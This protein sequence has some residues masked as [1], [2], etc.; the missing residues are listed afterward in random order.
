MNETDNKYINEQENKQFIAACRAPGKEDSAQV[1]ENFL[2]KPLERLLDVP[3]LVLQQAVKKGDVKLVNELLKNGDEIAQQKMAGHLPYTVSLALHNKKFD[4]V[5]ILFLHQNDF[6]QQELPKLTVRFFEAVLK[7]GNIDL[8]KMILECGNK[9]VQEKLIEGAQSALQTVYDSKRRTLPT[10][11]L[12]DDQIKYQHKRLELMNLLLEHPHTDFQKA[13]C[14]EAYL[15]LKKAIE[16]HEF[17]VCKILLKYKHIVLKEQKQRT[18]LIKTF[19]LAVFVSGLPITRFF[20]DHD[21][22]FQKEILGGIKQALNLALL[23]GKKELVYKLVGYCLKKEVDL[24]PWIRTKDSRLAHKIKEFNGYVC[25]L[26]KKAD[27]YSTSD[28]LLKKSCYLVRS[29]ETYIFSTFHQEMSSSISLNS[30]EKLN[31]KYKD[32]TSLLRQ[33]SHP[34]EESYVLMSIANDYKEKYQKVTGKDLLQVERA[35]ENSL[36]KKT[37]TLMK[38]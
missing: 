14:A 18:E 10:D 6:F 29:K 19:R 25:S 12:S 27:E 3:G 11:E 4:I 21:T 31:G 13:L 23:H 35:E 36:K 28:E 5:K 8:L 1:I 15:V 34:E 2:K 22:L 7:L 17:D 9:R 38:K 16:S 20:L 33:Y 32:I 30:T 37:I 24:S 26:L